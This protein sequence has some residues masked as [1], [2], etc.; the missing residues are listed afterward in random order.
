MHSAEAEVVPLERA[1]APLGNVEHW[2][3]AIESAMRASLRKTIMDSLNSYAAT[4]R[5]VSLQRL[6]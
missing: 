5:E 4:P 3:G 2:L 6:A 1:V